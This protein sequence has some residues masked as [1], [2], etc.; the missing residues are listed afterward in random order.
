MLL[1]LAVLGG[2]LPGPNGWDLDGSL[3]EIARSKDPR[4]AAPLADVLRFVE[5]RET[6]LRV[7]RTFE[8]V[9]G[10]KIL[11]DRA[12]MESAI[13]WVGEKEELAT[14]E[15]YTAWKGE[16]LARKIDPRYRELLYEGAPA[17]IR[18]QEV[19]WGGVAVGGIP[20]LLNPRMISSGQATY[21]IAEEPVFGVSINGDARAYP[22][23]ILDWH[24]MAN[25]VVGGRPVA[26]AY[27]TLCGAGILFDT[28]MAGGDGRRLFGSSG[29]LYRSN[30]LMFDQETGTI[31]NQFTGEPVIGKLA[32][33]DTRLAILPLVLTSWAEW[34]ARHPATK[35]VDIQTGFTRDY[36]VG[37]TYGAY[38]GSPGTMFPVWKQSDILPRKARVYGVRLGMEAKAYPLDEIARAG[39]VVNDAL[40][41]KPL[42]VAAREVVGRVEL[43]ERWRRATGVTH[44]NGLT[45]DK[46]RSALKKSPELTA[47][48]TEEM[49]LAMPVSTRLPLLEEHTPNE[50]MGDRAGKGQFSPNLRNAVAQRG[51]IG[52]TRAY[53]RGSHTFQRSSSADE[54]VDERGRA[55]RVTEDHLVGPEGERLARLPGHLAYWF[56][57]YAFLPRSEVYRAR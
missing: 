35:V 31:W 47:E 48:L 43:P 26:L 5:D 27:C 39:G 12:P 57:W 33:T 55:W 45:L 8:R 42:V 1:A 23:R 29:L 18:V 3:R 4:W 7:A 19:Q 16:L 6:V 56:G 25:D 49:L 46:A 28:A 14:P 52:E 53:E 13:V 34:K 54:L 30:K 2:L 51:L 40:G 41:S 22:L 36:Q 37:A 11:S 50:R 15:G 24:E 44:A 20:A 17:K 21:L 10:K 32:S 9:S 38:F